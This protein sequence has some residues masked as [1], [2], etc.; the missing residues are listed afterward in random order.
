MD[1]ATDLK[2]H[3]QFVKNL[4]SEISVVETVIA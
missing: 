2:R 1:Q 4:V 3:R